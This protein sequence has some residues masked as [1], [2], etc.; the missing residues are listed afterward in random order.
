M[1]I[2]FS[3]IKTY[4][5]VSPDDVENMVI[6]FPATDLLDITK[7]E[8]LLKKLKTLYQAHDLLLPVSVVGL[9]LLGLL[10]TQWIVLS[11]HK[12]S[13]YLPLNNIRLQVG[14]FN[15]TTPF[16]TLKIQEVTLVEPCNLIEY[17]QEHLTAPIET[18]AQAGDVKSSLIYNQFGAR[19]TSLVEGFMQYETNPTVQATCNAFFRELKEDTSWRRNPFLYDPVYIDNPYAPGSQTMMRSSCCMF[20]RRKNGV[21]CYN[22]PTLSVKEREK[23]AQQLNK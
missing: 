3:F 19:A 13:L 8:Q 20:Y 16:V 9:S 2:D 17:V 6:D 7:T 21:K 12:K 15:E 1:N 10:G 18:I 14:L 4:C 23:M 11:Q 5:Q 22:C